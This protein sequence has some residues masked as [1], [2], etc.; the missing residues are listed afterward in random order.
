MYFCLKTKRNLCY[1]IMK[2]SLK[3]NQIFI[4][5]VLPQTLYQ[6]TFPC[7]NIPVSVSMQSD[8]KEIDW[9]L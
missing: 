2:Q 9:Q 4:F 5:S 3:N 8:D 6:L 7:L 1:I